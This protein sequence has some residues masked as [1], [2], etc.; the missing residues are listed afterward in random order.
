MKGRLDDDEVSLTRSEGRST[1]YYRKKE[2][3]PKKLVEGTYIYITRKRERRVGGCR[4][5]WD[6]PRWDN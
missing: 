4:L 5:G 6:E 2:V 3:R 1:N